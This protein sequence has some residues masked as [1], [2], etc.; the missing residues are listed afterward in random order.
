MP[1]PGGSI[2]VN[3]FP[4]ASANG[5]A[6]SSR[7]PFLEA[8]GAFDVPQ[9]GQLGSSVIFPAGDGHGPYAR[10]LLACWAVDGDDQNQV[11]WNH[12]SGTATVHGMFGAYEYNAYAV[13]VP[14]GAEL[15]PVGVAGT[16]N[17]NGLEYDACPLY[18]I[19]QFTPPA[20][21]GAGYAAAF[22]ATAPNT[23]PLQPPTP[24]FP[25]ISS[26]R[27]AIAGCSLNLQQDWAPVFTKLQFDVWNEEEVK[28]TGAYECAD[29]WHE[30]DFRPGLDV[31]NNGVLAP[32][33]PGFVDG[34]DA[35]GQNFSFSTLVSYSARYRVQGLKSAQCDRATGG[36]NDTVAAVTTVAVGLIG[37]QS[38]AAVFGPAADPQPAALPG[39]LVAWFPAEGNYLDVVG[40]HDGSPLGGVTFAPGKVG[41]AF[42]FN[43]LNGEVV[44]NHTAALDFGPG[45]SFTLSAWVKPTVPGLDPAPPLGNSSGTIV[46]LTYFC[47]AELITLPISNT[48]EVFLQVRDNLGVFAAGT[49]GS[50]GSIAN[51]QWRH[52]VGVRDVGTDQ[53]RLYVDGVLVNSQTDPSTGTF[54]RASSF[55]TQP[56][57]I[58]SVGAPCVSKRFY[59][60][61]I[62]DVQIYNRALT[63]AEILSLTLRDVSIVGTTLA[64]AG[65]FNG[66]IVWDA[67]RAVPEGG[68]R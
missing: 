49:V 67:N 27:L 28:F 66:K 16:L 2:N 17:L 12:L 20:V 19:G 11:K 7:H 21:T 30:T 13:F 31:Q 36:A 59:R 64:G 6:V 29:S 15:G 33:I 3:P 54:T 26:N 34:M 35:A 39:G 9:Q 44:L 50:P 1:R 8:G 41:Q 25:L 42:S 60:G 37:V 23:L 45:D 62:D 24:S 5:F 51:G 47:T 46:S 18:Q 4:M 43:G 38:T 55:V 22:T 57:R 58:G 40:N 65:K 68:I 56:D 52:V 53:V 10:G 48:G 61:L 63:D 32:G 14:A